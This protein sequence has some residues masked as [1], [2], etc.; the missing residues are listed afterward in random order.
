MEVALCVAKKCIAVSWKSDSTLF[1]DK[2]SF[3][4]K[5]NHISS[6]KTVSHI[7]ENLAAIFRPHRRITYTNVSDMEA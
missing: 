2:W 4:V 1:I 3:D 6:Q 7:Y 5:K